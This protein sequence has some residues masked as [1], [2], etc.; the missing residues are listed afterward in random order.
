MLGF[1]PFLLSPSSFSQL[2]KPVANTRGQGWEKKGKTQ[3]A[4]VHLQWFIPTR[5]VNIEF[6]TRN[7]CVLN[8]QTHICYTPGRGKIV[9][10]NVI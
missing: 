8:S 7:L 10:C 9:P 5:M 2:G 1:F 3:Q 4:H 6:G